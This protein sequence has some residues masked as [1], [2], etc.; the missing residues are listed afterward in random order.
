MVRRFLL[1]RIPVYTN[2]ALN[3]VDVGDVARGHVLADE[4]GLVGERY[5]LGNRNYTTD[6]LFADLARL[7]GVEYAAAQGRPDGRAAARRRSSRA[8]SR[9]AARRSA[10]RRSS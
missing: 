5:I 10:P 3:V 2:G 4:R 6:R 7:S 8:S 1:G 9:A